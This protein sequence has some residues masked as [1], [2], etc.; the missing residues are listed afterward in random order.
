MLL[1]IFSNGF[2][3]ATRRARNCGDAGFVPTLKVTIKKVWLMARPSIPKAM[4][5][6]RVGSRRV[7][8]YI[9]AIT[10]PS[11]SRPPSPSSHAAPCRSRRP[12]ADT[13]MRPVGVLDLG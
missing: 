12:I 2:Y 6:Q 7:D 10:P 1:N 9:A 5:F 8:Q 11:T 13:Q 3:A 4:G